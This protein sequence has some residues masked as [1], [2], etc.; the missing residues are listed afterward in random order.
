M[1]HLL[2]DLLARSYG[3]TVPVFGSPFYSTRV[4]FTVYVD[5]STC[6]SICFN[7][8]LASSVSEEF[9]ALY[10]EGLNNYLYYVGGS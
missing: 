6:S 7:K 9:A 1:S 8:S 5:C 4:R 2:V 10:Y 3:H